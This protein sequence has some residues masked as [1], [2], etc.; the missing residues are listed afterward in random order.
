M[1]LSEAL[2]K[3]HSLADLGVL[4]DDDPGMADE[5]DRQR[6]A[7]DTVGDF[8]S[9]H[10]EEL[11]STWGDRLPADGDP[12]A[13]FPFTDLSG[14]REIAEET[15]HPLARAMAI[16]IELGS[17]QMTAFD[18]GE[19]AREAVRMSIAFWEQAGRDICENTASIDIGPAA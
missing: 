12:V 2:E 18:E 4:E 8:I 11:D 7:V 10:W 17:Q 3:M 5:I 13:D 1:I 16:A 15:G 14:I 19:E 9:N 6:D